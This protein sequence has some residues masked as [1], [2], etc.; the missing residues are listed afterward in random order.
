MAAIKTDGTLWSWGYGLE[1]QI[2]DNNALN[3][4]SP[5]QEITSSTTWCFISGTKAIKK[6]G[7]LWAWGWNGCGQ[8]GD[9]TITNRSSP[10]RESTLSNNW[11]SVSS[12]G[13][14]TIGLKTVTTR[15]FFGQP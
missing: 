11:S 7:S 4:S 6:D 3:R 2:G 5:V 14:V 10:V 12:A 13:S 1:G 9:G 8:L 15:G